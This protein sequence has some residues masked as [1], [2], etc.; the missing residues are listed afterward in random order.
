[1]DVTGTLLDGR[2]LLH[3]CLGEGGM[4]SIFDAEDL[5]LGRFVAVK[6]VRNLGSDLGGERLFR[7]AKA[8]ARTNHPSV[9][10]IYGYG[11]DIDQG[12]DY[13][14]ME[15]LQ[16]E[17]LRARIARSGALPVGFVVALAIDVADA[18]AAVHTIGVIHRDLKPANVF[19]AQRGLRVDE[20]K[21][22]DFGIAKHLDLQSITGPDQL[23]GTLPYMAPEQLIDAGRASPATDIY[24]LGVTLFECL[25]GVLPFSGETPTELVTQIM[26]GRDPS[27]RA[28]RPELPPQLVTCV[29]TCLQPSPA[30]RFA[31]ARELCSALQ[32]LREAITPSAG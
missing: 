32:A 11:T 1:M 4:A 26:A 8:A 20:V 5:T 14:V 25:A 15:R 18:L 10:T 23:I 21:V 31:S 13:L 30:R 9:V 29:E 12:I 16:G 28:R 17:D 6:L 2:Y 27:L 3:R 24:A 7:E 19:L 22:L